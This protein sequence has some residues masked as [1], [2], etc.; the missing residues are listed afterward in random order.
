MIMSLQQ[1]L[2]TY[3]LWPAQAPMHINGSYDARCFILAR[4]DSLS[5]RD[6]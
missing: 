6:S 3:G 1:R 5:T 4:S 2:R